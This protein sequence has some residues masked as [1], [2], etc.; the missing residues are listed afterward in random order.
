[1]KREIIK[2]IIK[3]GETQGLVFEDVKGKKHIEEDLQ[4]LITKIQRLK[5]S[6]KTGGKGK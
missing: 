1:M 6:Q 5:P 2:L 4:V 3:W